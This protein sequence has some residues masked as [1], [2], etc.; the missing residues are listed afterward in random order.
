VLGHSL[1]VL[2]FNSIKLE[3]KKI[4]KKGWCLGSVAVYDLSHE[5]VDVGECSVVFRFT[6]LVF[7]A[8]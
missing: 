3:K 5:F 8:G 7:G 4:E 1:I 6:C 2:S